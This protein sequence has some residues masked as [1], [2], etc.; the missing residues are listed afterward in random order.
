MTKSGLGGGIFIII[1]AKI[2]TK[3][4]RELARQGKKYFQ[5]R[6]LH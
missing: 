2:D 5:K 4:Q 6:S 1:D 3:T